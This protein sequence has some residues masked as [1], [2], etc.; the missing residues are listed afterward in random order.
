V[1]AADGVAVVFM[2]GV[3][4]YAWTGLADFGAGFWDLIAGGRQRG[5]R[6]RALIDSAI[7]TVWEANHV[8]LVFCIVTCWTA[9]G[10]AFASIMTTLFIPLTLAALGI[11]LRGSSFA[12]RK[13]AERA[14]QRH[15]A[16]WTFGLGSLVTPFFLGATVGALLAGRVPEGNA[17]GDRLTSW[18]NPTAVLVGLLAMALGAFLAAVYLIVEAHHRGQRD[19]HDYFRIRALAAGTVALLVGIGALLALRADERRMFDRVTGRGLALL[20]VA[21]VALLATLLLAGR[22]VQR[23]LRVGGALAVGALVW[24]WGVSQYPYLLPFDLTIDDGAGASVTMRWI[25][26]WF[27]VALVTAVPA[28]MLLYVLEQRGEIADEGPG[29]GPARGVEATA[30][31]R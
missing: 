26:L 7:G 22:R 2:V 4:L 15:V 28:L 29:P 8:W 27:L 12:F 10:V 11:V 30:G 9:F 23:G 3:T 5:G 24:T 14:R 19:L 18:A 16:G 6:P 21:S 31:E 17:A 20:I 1:T 13:N 25:L